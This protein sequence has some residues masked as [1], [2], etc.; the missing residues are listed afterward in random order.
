M[1]SIHLCDIKK[2]E[3][4]LSMRQW[5]VKNEKMPEEHRGALYFSVCA[6]AL[7]RAWVL[8]C[9]VCVCLCVCVCVVTHLMRSE[10]GLKFSLQEDKATNEK[11]YTQFRGSKTNVKKSNAAEEMPRFKKCRQA[12]K[13]KVACTYIFYIA[14]LAMRNVRE[15]QREISKKK[16]RE[17]RRGYEQ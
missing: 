15:R 1:F 12:R 5:W 7:V 13:I 9:C 17:G 14:L 2:E 3:M 4:G 6:R 10:S 8:V 11:W 16:Q